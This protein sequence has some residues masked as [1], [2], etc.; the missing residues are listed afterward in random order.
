[1][2]YWMQL[3]ATLWDSLDRHQSVQWLSIRKK[4]RRAGKF[5]RMRK[6]FHSCQHDGMGQCKPSPIWIL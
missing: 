3:L 5:D 2:P 1:L 6:S 4:V